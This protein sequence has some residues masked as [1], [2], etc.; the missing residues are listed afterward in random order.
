MK[1]LSF[2]SILFLISFVSAYAA[3]H[4][5][6][7]GIDNPS[8]YVLNIDDHTFQIYYQVDGEL[9]AMAIDPELT[10]LLIALEN[11]SDSVFKID[12]DHE[13]INA[14]NNEFAIL[15]NG[16]EVEYEIVSDDNSSTLTF[17]VPEHTE[18]IEIIGTHVIPEFPL[19]AIF[20]LAVLIITITVISSRKLPVFRL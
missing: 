10:S 4:P 19:G 3:S 7:S 17:F 6:Y 8:E 1:F 15:V 11:T 16:F 12:L 18:E 20:G 13:L 9:I 5:E 2:F 14:H